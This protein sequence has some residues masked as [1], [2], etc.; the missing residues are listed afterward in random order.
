[1][2]GI[3]RGQ[4]DIY[5]HSQQ[6]LCFIIELII[7]F[8]PHSDGVVPVRGARFRRRLTFRHFYYCNVYKTVN[9]I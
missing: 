5:N 6:R 7:L 8:F 2:L 3:P 1:M 9:L 4:C